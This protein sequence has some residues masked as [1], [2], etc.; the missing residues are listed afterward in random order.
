MF[1]LDLFNTFSVSIEARNKYLH[2]INIRIEET[3]FFTENRRLVECNTK[4][5][6]NC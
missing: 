4:N 1:D 6:L 2:F 5:P 3:I